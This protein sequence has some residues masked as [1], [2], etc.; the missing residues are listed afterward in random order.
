MM[1]SYCKTTSLEIQRRMQ[2]LLLAVS[3]LV[4]RL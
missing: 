3:W 1:G 2:A 4:V